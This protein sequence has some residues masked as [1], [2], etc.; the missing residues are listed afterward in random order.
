MGCSLQQNA[1]ML[2]HCQHTN[3][4]SKQ[5]KQRIQATVFLAFYPPSPVARFNC[6]EHFP[7][8]KWISHLWKQKRKI[9]GDNSF[10]GNPRNSKSS[11]FL[12]C[13]PNPRMTT[14][15]RFNSPATFPFT[16]LGSGDGGGR[17]LWVMHAWRTAFLGFL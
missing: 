17:H 10:I 5:A 2:Q 11:L 9:R 14:I 13:F 16:F 15:D 7:T 8:T 12:P 4:V 6:L 1:K 3:S